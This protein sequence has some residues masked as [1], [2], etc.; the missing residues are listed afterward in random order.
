MH[1]CEKHMP[2]IL[3]LFTRLHEFMGVLPTLGTESPDNVQ[4]PFSAIS[5]AIQCLNL[6][7]DCWPT[8][9]QAC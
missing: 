8:S 7:K 6:F 9:T 2:H 5:N 3:D 4:E 1:Q